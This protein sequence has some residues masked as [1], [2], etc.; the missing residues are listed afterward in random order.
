MRT[1]PIIA[2]LFLWATGAA[3]GAGVECFVKCVQGKVCEIRHAG[4]STSLNLLQSKEVPACPEAQLTQG[5]LLQG[6]VNTGQGLKRFSVTRKD[7][8]KS[9]AEVARGLFA[10]ASCLGLHATCAET[11]DLSRVAATA[12]KGVDKT[13]SRRVGSPC[14]AGLPCGPIL[15]PRQALTFQLQGAAFDGSW[16]IT[17]LR[18]AGPSRA[19]EVRQGRIELKPEWLAPGQAYAYSLRDSAGS[20]TMAG[21]FEVLSRRM[22]ADVESLLAALPADPQTASFD[23]LDLLLGS[24]LWWDAMQRVR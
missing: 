16:Q 20:E 15:L 22:Q 2:A 21:E 12:G 8:G 10:S 13:V 14:A 3:Q 5:E 18:P 6:M 4:G 19:T 24:D 11:R 7:S 17:P 9:F 1:K 23:L